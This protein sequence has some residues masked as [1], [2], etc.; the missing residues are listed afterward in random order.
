MLHS[1]AVE[2]SFPLTLTLSLGE[3]EQLLRAACF[4][5]SG[6]ADTVTGLA[7]RTADDSPSPPGRG[8]G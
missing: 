5:H 4:A 3:R 7:Q 6:L 1:V 8:P 2:P